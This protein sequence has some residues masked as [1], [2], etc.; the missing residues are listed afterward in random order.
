VEVKLNL[1]CGSD[2]RWHYVNVDFRQTHPSVQVVDLSTLPWPFPD[3]CADEVMMLD[4]LEHFPRA[5]TRSIL[6]EC[7]RVLS[8]NGTLVVQVPDVEELAR[9]ICKRPP[10]FCNKCEEVFSNEHFLTTS[11]CRICSA[12]H[13]DVLDAAF[14]RMY[15]GQDYL[16]NFHQTGFTFNSLKNVLCDSGF[17]DVVALE[18]EHQLR[19]W[20]MKVSCKKVS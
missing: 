6:D 14:G 20:N 13:D 7:R 8:P 1:G 12:E 17:E 10:F 2:I 18:E 15:G 16:G 5:M 4:F 9:V 19:N 3:S 11:T